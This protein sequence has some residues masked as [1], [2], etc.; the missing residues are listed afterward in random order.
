MKKD[1]R[2]KESLDDLRLERFDGKNFVI[3]D[4]NRSFDGCI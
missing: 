3:E 4:P 2:T 1:Y